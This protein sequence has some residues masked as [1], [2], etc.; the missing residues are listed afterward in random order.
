MINQITINNFQSHKESQFNF[1]KG[2]NAIIGTSDHGKSAVI[3][4]LCW[5]IYNRPK[6]ISMA[7]NWIKDNG[8]LKDVYSVI[9]NKDGI[10]ITRKRDNDLNEYSIQEN[11]L[12]EDFKNVSLDVPK[13]ISEVIDFTE[14]NLQRQHD[15]PFLISATG[16]EVGIFFN[17]IVHMELIDKML[18]G[19]K[20]FRLNNN[21][22]IKELESAI[23]E[24]G[25]SIDNFNWISIAEGFIE[26]IE[27]YEKRKTDLQKNKEKLS[28]YCDQ[29]K[30]NDKIL[31]KVSFIK[32]I[33]PLIDKYIYLHDKIK[34][35]LKTLNK[36][37]NIYVDIK[38]N[39]KI[40]NTCNNVLKT[41][42]LFDKWEK[43]NEERKR[44]KEQLHLLHEIRTDIISNKQVIKTADEK[45]KEL[46]KELPIRCPVC[47]RSKI[48]SNCGGK[49]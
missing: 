34:L 41:I 13:R 4:A 8:K 29:I 23:I 25:V 45:I 11:D 42:P 38:N 44:I 6:G 18:T 20:S 47:G 16:G 10:L 21:R 14:V 40:I 32:E 24:I 3:R 27:I 36:F 35:E 5:A 19:I 31:N 33:E 7:S 1:S 39:S 37:K 26:K 22:E 43:Q 48:C 15:A 46:K 49:L 9:I 17:N 28:I 12:K 2:V 30:E